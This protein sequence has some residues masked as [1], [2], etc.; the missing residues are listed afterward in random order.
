MISASVRLACFPG[1]PGHPSHPIALSS[2]VFSF[3]QHSS[4]YQLLWAWLVFLVPWFLL[5]KF[6]TSTFPLAKSSSAPMCS[7]PYWIWRPLAC[8]TSYTIL[9]PYHSICMNHMMT[10]YKWVLAV[11]NWNLKI[12]VTEINQFTLLAHRTHAA[13]VFL[14]DTSVDLS[15]MSE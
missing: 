13:S 14:T 7:L 9:T 8:M 3:Y 10:I 1:A 6:Q 12:G 15:I 11:K 4:W 2:T 5:V